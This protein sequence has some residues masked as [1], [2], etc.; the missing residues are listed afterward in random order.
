MG[1]DGCCS[2]SCVQNASEFQTWKSRPQLIHMQYAM[3]NEA[4]GATNDPRLAK[5]QSIVVRRPLLS[6]CP[7]VVCTRSV[8]SKTPSKIRAQDDHR[9]PIKAARL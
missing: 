4:S 1:A 9:R 7:P 5:W 2:P 6:S 8:A 3:L